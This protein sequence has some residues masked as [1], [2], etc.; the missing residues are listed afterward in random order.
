MADAH[1]TEAAALQAVAEAHDQANYRLLAINSSISRWGLLWG[2]KT[3]MLNQALMKLQGAIQLQQTTRKQMKR[4][5]YLLQ[6][7][8][9]GDSNCARLSGSWR[10]RVW[11]PRRKPMSQPKKQRLWRK[12]KKGEGKGKGKETIRGGRA[13]RASAACGAWASLH[14]DRAEGGGSWAWHRGWRQGQQ[15][16]GGGKEAGLGFPRVWALRPEVFRERER[17]FWI[18]FPLWEFLRPVFWET[19]LRAFFCEISEGEREGA[20]ERSFA[21]LQEGV[22]RHSRS[23]SKR[24]PKAS[25]S[26]ELVPAWVRRST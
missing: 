4:M 25:T 6:P 20:R 16:Q 26:P 22:E 3:P 8:G 24:L 18:F 17:E 12:K 1:E 15:W 7:H 2:T 21:T 5:I 14:R 23:R 10:L 13:R 19:S 11:S 9:W